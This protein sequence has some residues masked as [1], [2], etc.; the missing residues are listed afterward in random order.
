MILSRISPRGRAIR[1]NPHWIWVKPLYL[2]PLLLSAC[3]PKR[4]AIP[5]GVEAI[6]HRCYET[7]ATPGRTP[8]LNPSQSM[9]DGTF[10][11]V[12]SMA[13]FPDERGS[14]T[15]DGSGVVL[16]LTSADEQQ[17]PEKTSTP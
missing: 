3:G 10:L 9:G 8:Q 16:L 15:V 6:A 7:L 17:Q 4:S 5:D 1:I 14:C 2:L 11:I 13:E 12:W